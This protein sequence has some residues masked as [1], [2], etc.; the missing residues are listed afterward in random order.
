MGNSWE[1][2]GEPLVL[3]V[4]PTAQARGAQVE[5]RA[6]A[7]KLDTPGMRRHRLL[8][9]FGG[10]DAIPVDL[11]LGRTGG[12]R[13]AEGFDWRVVP[14]LRAELARL[15]PAAVVAHGGEPLKFLVPAMT[16]LRVPLAYYAIGT[17][18]ESA[19]RQPRL[20]LWRALVRR[21]DVVATEGE[22]VL[23]ECRDLL[24]VP[25]S[26]LVLAPNCRDPEVFFPR[27]GDPGA[28][29][30][31]LFVGA[32]TA[33]K[34][35]DC[36]IEVVAALRS[37]GVALSAVMA[38]DGPLRASLSTAAAEAGVELLGSRSDVADLLRGADVFVFP[39]RPAGEG[40]PGVLIEAGMTGVPVVATA[41][42]GI[43]MIVADGE[44]GIVVPVD[45]RASMI[46]AVAELLA[47]PARRRAMG[48]AARRRC[49]ERFSLDAVSQRWL[50]FLTPLLER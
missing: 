35:P 47:D 16:G 18:A 43:P 15:R 28:P 27:S 38:G 45:D 29:P 12:Q 46:D 40:M 5:A 26:R 23:A 19:H 36:F 4:I 34:R 42:P 37:R 3:H 50:G 6:M 20:A 30:V 21:P 49:V 9:L 1:P 32:L 14:G 17:V 41:A 25:S 39:S 2:T 10:D 48:E 33:G 11:S 7:S 31:V 24:G 22:E 44:T 13:P 8:C